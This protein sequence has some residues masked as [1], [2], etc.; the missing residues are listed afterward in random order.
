MID[1]REARQFLVD[2][3]GH[4]SLGGLLIG[5]SRFPPDGGTHSFHAG[6]AAAADWAIG[7]AGQG[8][9]YFR[10]T[11]LGQAP[12]PG[13]RGASSD[14]RALVGLHGDIDIAGPAHGKSD[15]P[16]DES[17]A[18]RIISSVGL[19]PTLI[20]H[21]GHGLQ[22]HWLL[23]EPWVFLHNDR[24][25]AQTIARQFGGTIRAIAEPLG[26]DIDNVAD[27]ARLL[28][29]PGTINAKR[30][31]APVRVIERT[32]RR[33]TIDQIQ[34][35]LIDEGP[36]HQPFDRPGPSQIGVPRSERPPSA[37]FTGPDGELLA[38]ARQAKNG[39]MFRSLYDRGDAAPWGGDH[40]KAD[41]HLVEALAFWTGGSRERIDRLFRSSMLMRA[42]WDECHSS[43]GRSYGRMTIDDVL[44]RRTMFYGTRRPLPAV[45]VTDRQLRDQTADALKALELVNRTPTVFQ[46]GGDI[47][48]VRRDQATGHPMI[49]R[50]G[51]DE[52]VGL[53]TRC[54][55]FIRI[56]DAGKRISI[57]PPQAIARDILALP[58][59]RFPPLLGVVQSPRVRPD[60]T[61]L[62]KPGY[63]PAT[64]L[65][66]DEYQGWERFA[67]PDDP[68]DEELAAAIK[69]IEELLCDFRFVGAADRAN[70]IGF[71]LTMVLRCAIKGPVPVAA[72]DARSKQGTGKSLLAKVAGVVATGRMPVMSAIPTDEPELR[73]SLTA[74]LA[75]GHEAVVFDNATSSVIES[76]TWASCI[77]ADEFED[78]I[79]GASKRVRVPVRCSWAITGNAMAFGGDMVRRT[80][81][82]LQD[83]GV[84]RP[85]DRTGFRHELPAW[86]L[87]KRSELLRA[88]LILCRRWWSDGCPN[89]RLPT[90]GSFEDFV[91]IVGGV[92]ENAGITGFLGNRAMFREGADVDRSEWFVFVSA[93]AR[94]FERGHTFSA[95]D[96]AEAL[97]EDRDLVDALPASLRDAWEKE[98]GFTNRL[99][100]AL[101]THSG[102]VF[103]NY[104]LEAGGRDT[105]AKKPLYRA[106]QHI[107][108]AGYAG[109]CGDSPESPLGA[110][111]IL[112]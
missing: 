17:E 89:P 69:L 7:Q 83:A 36:Q 31:P 4:E 6:V 70:A 55:D 40:S 15:L 92:L 52:M 101:R 14:S 75:E 63:D 104:R 9:V 29:V 94:R 45:V 100:R 108:V 50:L 51:V 60:G 79:L 28:R 95:S 16:P 12:P 88:C 57:T 34:S 66:L 56:N 102:A 62:L 110:P 91:R 18:R 77:T 109:D 11:L 76:G 112:P 19:P 82:V 107:E 26:Y 86:A 24:T 35:V 48:R 93:L 5:M 111:H 22:P 99:G 47:V 23:T 10:T 65:W 41:W 39:E 85:E 64:K 81:Q 96:V 105:H 42:K 3:F 59:W 25:A 13:R 46:R 27:L 2:L 67:V 71:M 87:E 73:K 44:R 33:Y 58:E 84:E 43:D 8:N 106:V 74:L 54:A 78:R 98:K 61:L 1:L 49:Q 97:K 37:G 20:V 72:F 53:L 32:G 80:Y 21:S 68:T 30:E 90:W 103:G 38:A